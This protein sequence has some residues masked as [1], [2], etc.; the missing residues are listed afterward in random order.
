MPYGNWTT[1]GAR[2]CVLVLAC[3]K[4]CIEIVLVILGFDAERHRNSVRTK[5]VIGVT[6]G[7]MY[8]PDLQG[9]IGSY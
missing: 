7:F 9:E 6:N 8:L 3:D 5:I 1:N 4:L 2:S